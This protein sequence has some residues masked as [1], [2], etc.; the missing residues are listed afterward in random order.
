MVVIVPE[1]ELISIL[2]FEVMLRIVPMSR[3]ASS[4]NALFAA[5]VPS[6]IPSSFSRSVS[7]MLA[8]PITKLPV[9]VILPLAVIAAVLSAASVS[10]KLPVLLPVAVVVATI[11][12]SA[13]SSQP[14]NA[15]SP[16]EPRSIT[17]PRS[18]ALLD[19]PL[20]SSI[21]LSLTTEFVV[22]IVVVVPLTVKLPVTVRSLPI[23]TSSGRPIW[24]WLSETVVS[25]SFDV[26]AN[27]SVS[28]P[29]VTVSFEPLSAAIVRLEPL[30]TC[31]ST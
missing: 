15:L 26:P 3:F 8:E 20:L 21:R 10:D 24:I 9:V 29:T 5:A 16:V 23:V 14:I 7:F 22:L 11:N 28:V 30:D 19:A 31:V 2:P 4:T 17:I 1:P 12:V 25:I 27:V 6:V 13:L 18:L